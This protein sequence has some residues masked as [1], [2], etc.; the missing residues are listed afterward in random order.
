[1]KYDIEDVIRMRALLN[2]LYTI[3]KRG[4]W[5]NKE[6]DESIE[7]KLR[8]FIL[9]EVTVD[10]VKTKVTELIDSIET[11]IDEHLIWC[12]E[13]FPNELPSDIREQLKTNMDFQLWEKI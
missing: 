7:R 1:M 3:N 2:E 12:K 8:T 5:N 9:A 4:G 13:N 10:E 11:K 6:K